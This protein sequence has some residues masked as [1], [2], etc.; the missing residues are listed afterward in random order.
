MRAGTSDMAR[1]RGRRGFAVCVLQSRAM[2]D[3]R[4]QALNGRL[5]TER[6]FREYYKEGW[7]EKWTSAICG[8]RQP[9][10]SSWGVAGD[11]EPGQ[12][13]EVMLAS[14]ADLDQLHEYDTKMISWR[15]VQNELMKISN[16]DQTVSWCDGSVFP[17]WV[18]LGNSGRLRDV[19]HEGVYSVRVEVEHA[20]KDIVVVSTG[21][22]YRLRLNA[23]N[24][25]W[26][27]RPP[28]RKR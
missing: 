8:A 26:Q 2:G 10:A 12:A 22:T 6:E 14:R 1:E 7:E 25:R 9:A 23:N 27:I 16:E 4:R 5:Y 15:F 3:E 24:G 13:E 18:W 28:P 21:G 20:V 19:V 11:A 17:W